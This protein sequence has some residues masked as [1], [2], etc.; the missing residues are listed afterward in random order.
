MKRLSSYIQLKKE[1][2]ECGQFWFA[3]WRGTLNRIRRE[4]GTLVSGRTKQGELKFDLL[5]NPMERGVIQP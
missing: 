2:C 3:Y 1:W 4:D 5:N